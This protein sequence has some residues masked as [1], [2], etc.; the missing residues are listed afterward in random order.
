MQNMLCCGVELIRVGGTKER[1]GEENDSMVQPMAV[2]QDWSA[3]KAF[4]HLRLK[5]FFSL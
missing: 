1:K 2:R 4:K 3:V 5:S